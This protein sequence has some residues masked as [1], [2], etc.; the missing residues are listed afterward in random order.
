MKFQWARMSTVFTLTSRK[1]RIAISALEN[2][3]GF[4]QKTHSYR[5]AQSG[6]FGWLDHSGS[7]SSQWRKWITQH[8]SIRHCGTRFG[9][10][11]VTN[12]HVQS[13]NFS[14]D[15]EQPNEVLGA[16]EETKSRLHWQFLE[17]WQVLRGIILE[18]MYVNAA[19]IGNEWDC[20]KSGTQN[21]GRNFCSVVAIR[22]GWKMVGRFHGKSLLSAKHSRSLDWWE[23]TIW[24]VVRDVL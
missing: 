1:T 13:K 15:P 22:L 12:Q 14:G 6:K 24:K 23:D 10:T 5:R 9:N 18:S 4:L 17:I 20:W 16:D 21:K 7:Q 11:V 19:R 3:K 2:N 8:S